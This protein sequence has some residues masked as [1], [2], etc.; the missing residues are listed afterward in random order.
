M[1]QRLPLARA[2]HRI[3][4]LAVFPDLLDVTPYRLPAL[5]LA[6]VFL[7]HAAAHVI[8]AVPL[9]PAARIIRV[10]P[11]LL[12]PFGQMLASV[13]AEII[14]QAVAVFRRKF[15]VREPTRG[16]LL[17]TVGH[18][19]AA[20]DAEPKHL[21]RRQVGLELRIEA[22]A[23]RCN[24]IIAVTALHLIADS[25]RARLHAAE[26]TTAARA[27]IAF[28][29]PRL[30]STTPIAVKPMPKIEMASILSPNRR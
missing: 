12:A 8:A 27:A 7:R 30:A 28:T 15:R 4:G 14:E 25:Y 20:E 10:N 18:V 6:R 22:A 13:D 29:P 9:K 19:L 5:D 23:D 21:F 3:P 24:E 26:S 16:Q 2:A 17:A 1:Q 11:A